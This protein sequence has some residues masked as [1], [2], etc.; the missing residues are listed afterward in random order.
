MSN[1]LQKIEVQ[2]MFSYL[3]KQVRDNLG[4]LSHE[5]CDIV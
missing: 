2:E 5:E 3:K 4:S 1:K